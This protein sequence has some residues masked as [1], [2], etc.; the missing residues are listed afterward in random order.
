MSCILRIRLL[1]VNYIEA[2][3]RGRKKADSIARDKV[4]DGSLHLPEYFTETF[5]VCG[6]NYYGACKIRL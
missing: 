3:E 6:N 4:W 1:G 5:R 2:K